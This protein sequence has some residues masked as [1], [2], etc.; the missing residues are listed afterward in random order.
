MSD[1]DTKIATATTQLAQIFAQHTKVMHW[2]SSGK[3]SGTLLHLLRPYRH[4]VTILYHALDG[5]WPGEREHVEQV[6]EQWDFPH[7]II[8]TPPVTLEDYIAQCG[9][10]AN[11]VPTTMDTTLAPRSPFALATKASNWWHCTLIR[12]I[13]PMAAATQQAGVDAL[14]TGSRAEDAPAFARMGAAL[15]ATKSWGLH[16]YNPLQEWTR[17]DIYAYID[18]FQVPLPSYYAWK[19]HLPP[20][21]ECTDCLLCT[22]QPYLWQHII[23]HYYPSVYHAWWPQVRHFYQTLQAEMARDQAQVTALLAQKG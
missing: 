15:D 4:E 2:Y 5:V 1:L 9:F 22:W 6:L 20:E 10:P 12:C 8:S 21:I 17:A 7:R 11:T 16:R 18:R 23:P 3:D 13:E 19:R 14:L